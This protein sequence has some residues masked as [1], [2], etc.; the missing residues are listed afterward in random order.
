MRGGMRLSIVRKGV[1]YSVGTSFSASEGDSS[2]V[3]AAQIVSFDISLDESLRST[4]KIWLTPNCHKWRS[5]A[6]KLVPT[7]L[8]VALLLVHFSEQFFI[9][10]TSEVELG[11]KV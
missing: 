10:L 6:L 11:V 5:D 2:P 3:G 7:G 8:V 9:L 1:K 4:T